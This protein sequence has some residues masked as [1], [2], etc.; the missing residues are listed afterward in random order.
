[1]LD[2]VETLKRIESGIRIRPKIGEIKKVKHE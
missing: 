2:E 1:M